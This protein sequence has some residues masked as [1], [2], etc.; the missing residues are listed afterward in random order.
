MRSRFTIAPVALIAAAVALGGCAA[1]PSND[2]AADFQGVEREVA[3][4]IDEL[5]AAALDGDAKKICDT[6]FA[7]A[8]KDRLGSD[9]VDCQDALEDQLADVADGEI[10]VEEVTVDGDTATARVVSPYS[11]ED[12]EQ[13]LSFER[14]GSAWR[15]TGL[16]PPG[17]QPEA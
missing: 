1:A 7:P 3:E 10:D 12:V 8:L 16:E 13:T 11:G 4:V 9:G 6:I 15:I 2:A 14:D 17:P 5:S